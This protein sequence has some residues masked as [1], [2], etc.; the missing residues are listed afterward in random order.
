MKKRLTLLVALILVAVTLFGCAPANGSAGSTAP[1]A[2]S[3]DSAGSAS[4]PATNVAAHSKTFNVVS[5]D[6]LTMLDPHNATTPADEFV[7]KMCY[8]SVLETDHKG[9]FTPGLA[10]SW[11]FNADCTELT[12]HLR[13]GVK[14]T[15]GEPFNA[16]DFVYNVQ[17]MVDHK[18]DFAVPLY[19]FQSLTGAEKIDDYTA[20]MIFSEPYPMALNY[21][22]DFLMIPMEAHKQM[23]DQMFIDMK[24]IGTGPWIFD[25]WVSGQYA[26]VKKNPDYWDKANYDSYFDDGYI[27]FVSEPS[28]AAAAEISGDADA[29]IAFG[30]ISRDVMPLYK[31]TEDKIQ[32]VE[33]DMNMYADLRLGFPDG[34]PF[35]D[36]K[37]RE[38]LDLAIDRQALSQ[39][40]QGGD[41]PTGVLVPGDVGYDSAMKP[42]EY[43]PD[44]AK[45]L[46]SQ[47]SYDGHELTFLTSNA[48]LK[49]EDAGLAITSML[50]DV[51]FK[52]NFKCE[53]LATFN[54]EKDLG[55]W[56]LM[57]CTNQCINGDPYLFFTTRYVTDYMK[58]GFKGAD[59]DALSALVQKFCVEPDPSV[60]DSIAKQI[61]NWN[62]DWHGPAL[63]TASIKGVYTVTNGMTGITIF[64]DGY[65]SLKNINWSPSSGK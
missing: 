31:G 56:D 3:G 43:N 50:Q 47:S 14:F 18:N 15:N 9:N 12:F 39:I 51:G 23:G 7:M 26:H 40:Y 41:A 46:L 21:M 63:A 65:E 55:K 33:T 27:R 13:Q 8:D 30:G 19:Y 37:C 36:A 62:K 6:T 22:H 24:Q 61:N 45:E 52:I 17:R 34:S 49:C 11:E 4:A 59:A 44:K 25:E 60:R 28:S 54:N 57:N 32:V 20:K 42:Y 58:S 38:A 5:G 53:D 16:D 48:F 10:T 29:Y 35:Y 2:P 1:A 64:P